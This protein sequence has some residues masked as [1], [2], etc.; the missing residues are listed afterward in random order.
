MQKVAGRDAARGDHRKHREERVV[1]RAQ[2]GV[3]LGELG[4]T[5]RFTEG[6]ELRTEISAKFTPERI[7]AELDRAGFAVEETWTVEPGYLLTLARPVG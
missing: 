1:A 4:A 3:D 6:E 2:V 5:V 7:A